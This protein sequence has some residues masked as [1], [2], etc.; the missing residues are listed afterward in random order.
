M[1]ALAFKGGHMRYIARSLI[2]WLFFCSAGAVA[3]AAFARSEE[4]TSSSSTRPA[5]YSAVTSS[6]AA[7]PGPSNTGVPEGVSLAPYTGPCAITKPQT[8]I[9]AKLVNC[10]L[11]IRAAGVVITRSRVNGYISSDSEKSTGYSFTLEDSE[12]NASPNGP[13]AVTAVGEVNFIVRRSHIYGGSRTANCW[14]NCLIEDSWLHG[15]DTDKL[16]AW[17]ESAVR[18]G[19]N[20]VIRHNTLAC[21]APDIPPDAGCS[22]SLTGYGDFGPV[23]NNIIEGNWFPGTTG[24]F[25]AYGGS[26]KGKPYS[27]SAKNVVF[28]DNVFGKGRSGKCGVWGPITDFDFTRPGNQWINNTWENGQKIPTP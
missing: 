7:W 3:F 12:V 25:C 28:K 1:E 8:I 11:R 21:D 13:R 19:E 24:G 17:H 2:E 10:D 26:S 22:A 9:D 23:Q 20:A 27:N 15:Q 5:Q 4:P 14:Q 6:E 18:M 16:G